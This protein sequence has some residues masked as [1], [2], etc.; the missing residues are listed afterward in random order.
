MHLFVPIQTQK[1]IKIQFMQ[2]FVTCFLQQGMNAKV[3]KEQFIVF[4]AVELMH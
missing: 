2:S 1:K 4:R 3:I